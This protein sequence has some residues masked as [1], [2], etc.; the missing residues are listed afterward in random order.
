MTL[1]WA[2]DV[3]DFDFQRFVGSVSL[4]D[5][6]KLFFDPDDSC[7]RLKATKSST[8]GE[9]EYPLATD[10]VVRGPLFSPSKV[11][12]WVAFDVWTELPVDGFGVAVTSIG[13]RLND[14]T[15]D[16][17]WNGAAWATPGASDWSTLA[18]IQDHV[19]TLPTATHAI[20]VVAN[21]RTTDP[22]LTPKLR[23]T[24]LLYKVDV[25]SFAE[26]VVLRTLVPWLRD[27]V[28]PVGDIDITWPG[29]TTLDL[30]TLTKEDSIEWT[31][32]VAAFDLTG[33]PTMETN[34]L[35]SYVPSTKVVTLTSA[36]AAARIVRL[37]LQYAPVV[38]LSTHSD[39]VQIGRSPS[40]MIGEPEQRLSSP[41]AVPTTFVKRSDGSG[42]SIPGPR[43]IDWAATLRFASHRGPDAM[44]LAEETQRWIA[45]NRSLRVACVDALLDVVIDT[46]VELR[47]SP[48][49]V[50][51][52]DGSMRIR[53]KGSHLWLRDAEV[54]Y[55]VKEIR[56]TEDDGHVLVIP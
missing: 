10:L 7:V 56:V 28:R 32:G 39:W 44:R 31:A 29:G 45:R 51:R 26:E 6:T 18:Q 3:C 20:R 47:P 37:K 9:W 52:Y 30:D 40:I 25:E 50:H 55:G 38:A 41:G 27:N 19:G 16:K 8:T 36:V 42:W 33:D 54:G 53:L 21:L 5:T 1:R 48:G 2:S 43:Q 23:E 34:L 17:W 24:R 11:R 15:T 46:D 49:E 4:S 14:G 12:Q 35:Q 22:T 13:W